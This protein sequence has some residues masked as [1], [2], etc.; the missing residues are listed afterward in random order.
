M[1]RA[2]IFAGICGFTT[3]VDANMSGEECALSIRSD[4]PNVQRLAENL[5]SVDPLKEISFR[6]EGPDTLQMAVKHCR[7]TACPVPSGIIKAVEVAAGLALPKDATIRVMQ[8]E[9]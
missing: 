3:V 9:G 5:S 8:S 1:A 4:C 6:R 2:E 7:H